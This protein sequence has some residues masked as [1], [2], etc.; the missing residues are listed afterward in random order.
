MAVSVIL[1]HRHVA[2][3]VL[4]EA[5]HRYER[6]ATWLIAAWSLALRATA[7]SNPFAVRLDGCLNTRKCMLRCFFRI[8]PASRH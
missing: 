3:D 7:R 4:I 5:F 6:L 1:S 8:G 2:L